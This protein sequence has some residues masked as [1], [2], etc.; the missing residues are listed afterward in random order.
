MN[1][2]Y[3]T[4]KDIPCGALYRLFASVGWVDSKKQTTEEMLANFNKPFINSD[5]VISAWDDDK[6]IGCIR[7]LSDTMFRSVI[8]DLAVLPECQKYGIGSEL[9]NKCISAYPDSEW[10]L[11]TTEN[12]VSFYEKL[13]F[14]LNSN[15]CMK[16]RCKWF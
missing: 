5:V 3:K 14:E 1:I 6:L 4:N 9:V 16:I 8:Y 11:E 2:T 12:R 15:P 7:A 13:G 10:V